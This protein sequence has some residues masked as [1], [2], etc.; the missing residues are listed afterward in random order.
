MEREDR[1]PENTKA[2]R[3]NHMKPVKGL[4]YTT[5]VGLVVAFIVGVV[6]TLIAENVVGSE[7]IAFSTVGLVSFLFSVALAGASIVLAIAAITLGRTSEQAMIDRSD[8]SIRLQN[9]IFIKTTDALQRIESS[10]GVTEKRIEDIISGR[11]GDISQRVAERAFADRRLT[12]GT[13]KELAEEIRESLLDELSAARMKE[14]TEAAKKRNKK[15]AEAADC[16]ARFKDATLLALANHQNVK[17]EKIAEGSVVASKEGLVDGIFTTASVRFGVASF[18]A[19]ELIRE[20]YLPYFTN[21]LTK[22][23]LE[24]SRGTFGKVFLVFEGELA[25]E[26]EFNQQFNQIKVLMQQEIA[27]N[28]FLIFGSPSDISD[29]ILETVQPQSE[30]AEGD[31]GDR[32]S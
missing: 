30:E 21:Y 5:L 4:R 19:H 2:P 29:R 22:L 24:I 18:S 26:D 7:A 20:K 1:T 6:A 27:D 17:S 11:V 23:S 16:Y 15:E 13:Q 25:E 31:E 12:G 32:S 9:D 10:T 14:H 8:E 3:R 28:L